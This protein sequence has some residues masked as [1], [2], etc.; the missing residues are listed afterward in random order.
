[1]Q[2]AASYQVKDAEILMKVLVSTLAGRGGQL[3][4]HFQDHARGEQ[5]SI[6]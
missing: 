3:I 5:S 4:A 1:M 2:G 6:R